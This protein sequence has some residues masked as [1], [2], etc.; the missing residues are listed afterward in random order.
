MEASRCE[1][2]PLHRRAASCRQSQGPSC[3]GGGWGRS[4]ST[5]LSRSYRSAEGLPRSPRAGCVIDRWPLYLRRVST[6]LCLAF[7]GHSR[8]LALWLGLIAD[9]LSTLPVHKLLRPLHHAS[10]AKL[11][12]GL[13]QSSDHGHFL[14]RGLKP[15]MH[16]SLRAMTF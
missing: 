12:L 10:L 15:I 13:Q 7:S 6:A 5:G 11:D 2:A 3:S 8:A 14:K 16:P 1:P 4:V 9:P